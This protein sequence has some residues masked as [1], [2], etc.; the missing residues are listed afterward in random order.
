MKQD[1]VIFVEIRRLLHINLIHFDANAAPLTAF[2]YG[3]QIAAIGSY[4][5]QR[6]IEVSDLEYHAGVFYIFGH[7]ILLLP[8]ML[9]PSTLLHNSAKFVCWRIARH[10]I[11][12]PTGASIFQSCVQGS[13]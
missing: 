2:L 8:K 11:E 10:N 1:Q 7:R 12:R 4:A 6:W 9:H 5:H 3:E 13:L